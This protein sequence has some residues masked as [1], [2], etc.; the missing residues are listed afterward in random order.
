M[1]LRADEAVS[2]TITIERDPKNIAEFG[3]LVQ[4]ASEKGSVRVKFPSGE[5]NWY[6][7]GDI[8]IPQKKELTK[9]ES[10]ANTF[11]KAELEQWIIN[12]KVAAA[13]MYLGSDIDIKIY[14]VIE[15]I[16]RDRKIPY[17]VISQDPDKGI[18]NAIIIYETNG[19]AKS[20]PQSDTKP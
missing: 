8:Q 7:A 12:K 4:D 17:W 2:T 14:F 5:W 15:K 10:K 18:R 11:N 19:I 6:S 1:T 13:Q 16:L 3:Q 9:W 20:I